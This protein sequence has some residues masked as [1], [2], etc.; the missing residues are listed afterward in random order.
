MRCL[1]VFLGL[2]L[3]ALPYLPRSPNPAQ[4]FRIQ[5]AGSVLCLLLNLFLPMIVKG[6]LTDRSVQ[7][8]IFFLTIINNVGMRFQVLV[9][10][11]VSLFLIWVTIAFSSI[12][13]NTVGSIFTW[14]LWITVASVANAVITYGRELFLRK[15][16]LL[17]RQLQS[18]RK[19]A[20]EFLYHM[21]PRD[22][23]QELRQGHNGVAEEFRDLSI[24]Y[25]GF[26][27]LS[28]SVGRKAEIFVSFPAD[29]KGFTEYSAS[30]T[31]ERVVQL[32]STLFTAFD[33]LNSVH[34]VYKIQ[35]IGDVVS[36]SS[37]VVT[38]FDRRCLCMLFW[39]SFLE[40]RNP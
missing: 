40:A 8:H 28:F 1:I 36:A 37:D 31:P 5:Y 38:L 2:T 19:K 35:T 24:L 13:Q 3:L 34:N 16:F 7:I 21:L 23:A 6:A 11:F 30:S 10:S 14:I 33:Q 26:F 39:C 29:I 22:V 27:F 25:S 12:G 20:D 18:E 32:L 15:G 4:L 17:T 9:P